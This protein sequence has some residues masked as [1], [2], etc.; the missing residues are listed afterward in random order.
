M[1]S[2][3]EVEEAKQKAQAGKVK[4]ERKRRRRRRRK[5]EWL[6]QQ[7]QQKSSR[8]LLY[9]IIRSVDMM[10]KVPLLSHNCINQK[11]SRAEPWQKKKK[12]KGE[13]LLPQEI[14]NQRLNDMPLLCV[15]YLLVAARHFLSIHF[16]TDEYSSVIFIIILLFFIDFSWTS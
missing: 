6:V 16:H 3:A 13:F 2:R 15:C 9:G 14:F 8:S 11:K 7:Q 5:S 1:K 4:P 12:K 10:E